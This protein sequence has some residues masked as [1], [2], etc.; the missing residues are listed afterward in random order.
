MGSMAWHQMG[1]GK[2]LSCLWEARHL[3]ATLR[4]G[5]ATAPKFMV[6]CPKSAVPT[7]KV[8]CY[9]E[10]RDLM[11]DMIIVPY[12]QLHN[13]SKKLKYY[14]LRMIIFDESH[15]LK[16]TDTERIRHLATFMDEV[17]KI[18]NQFR[19]GRIILATGTP[20]PN[21]AAELYTSWALCS[22]KHPVQAA[23]WITDAVRI[24]Q[25]KHTFAKRQEI[26][27][28]VGKGKP[29]AQQKRG[30]AVKL[31]GVDN[32]DK[33]WALMNPIV[34]YVPLDTSTLPPKQVNPVDLSLPDDDLLRDADLSRPEAYMALVERLARAKTPYMMQWVEDWLASTSE[35]LIVFAMNRYPI[36]QLKAKFPKKVRLIV[37]SGEGSSAAD[38]AANLA[39]F[40]AG[41]FQVLAMT[42][43]AGSES[44]NCQN[45]AYSLYLGYPWNSAMLDQAM[46]RTYRQGQKRPT[47]HYVLTSGENDRRILHLVISKKET[48]ERVQHLLLHGP[49]SEMKKAESL[50]DLYY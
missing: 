38:R 13:V 11:N 32:E 5:G 29:Q 8:E 35:Q 2:T 31:T 21:H 28:V 4:Q 10:T 27:W 50:L 36:D 37:G 7:W 14:D 30:H 12:S 45:C 43:A 47:S 41:K 46:A 18:N 6:V 19:G 3:M 40:Q 16:G 15:K 34:H 44:L 42:Y 33:L 23:E 26:S 1:L 48:T 24:D 20:L 9:Q 17:G 25:W 39:D 49:D 22:A